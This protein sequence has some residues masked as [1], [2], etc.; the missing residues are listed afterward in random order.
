[1]LCLILSILIASITMQELAHELLAHGITL[2]DCPVSGGPRGATA[3]TLTA[4]LGGSDGAV[5][6]A[7]PWVTETRH[8]VQKSHAIDSDCM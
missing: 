5:S 6:I 3:G 4:M 7:E 1:M 2:L 8:L